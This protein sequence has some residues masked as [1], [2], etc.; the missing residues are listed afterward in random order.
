MPRDVHVILT[1]HWDR[2]WI[3]SYEE[4]RYRLVRLFDKALD[5]LEAEPELC[6][7]ADGQTVL[8]DDYL[9]VRPAN[10]ERL[11]ALTRAGRLVFGPWYVLGDQFLACDE[12]LVRN[13]AIG[14]AQAADYGGAMREGYVPDSF[15]SVAALP[16]I[17]N[18]FGITSANLGRGS[19]TGRQDRSQH[20]F[21]WQ[22]ADG[23]RVLALDIGYG[24]GL[25]LSYPDIWAN[26]AHTP[27]TPALALEAA[28]A[29]LAHQAPGFPTN[30]VYASA[31]VDHME[32]RPGMGAILA[33][34]N[35]AL[36]DTFFASTPAR[37]LDAARGEVE[38]Q[39]I[40]LE[41]VA[42]EMRGD[43]ISPMSLQGVLS[44][45]M[46]LKIGNRRAE[47]ALT[48]LLEPL[49]A[50]LYGRAYDHADVIRHA[51]KMVLQSQ[52]H[53]SICATNDDSTMQ[54]IHARVRSVNELAQLASE[55]LL[56]EA[57]PEV[58]AAPPALPELVLFGGWPGGG[59]LTA[60]TLVRLPQRLGAARYTVLN[61]NGNAV[62]ALSVLAERQ[63]DLETYY[64]ADR[65]LL[66][67]NVKENTAKA[68][69][70]TYT[71]ARLEVNLP[72]ASLGFHTLQLE[73]AHANPS[74][75]PADDTH[76]END[77]LALDV[78]QDGRLMLTHKPS[79]R[80]SEPFG[81]FE[82]MAE[83]GNAYDSL[84]VAGDQ[85]R[86]SFDEARVTSRLV[87]CDAVAQELL[88]TT[89]W[90]LPA[91]L[92]GW[93]WP[94]RRV[95]PPAEVAAQRSSELVTLEI[96]TLLRLAAGSERL[97]AVT[98]L[99]NNARLHRLRLG[100]YSASRE[101]VVAG[102]HFSAMTRPWGGPT[103]PMTDWLRLGDGFTFSGAGL[104]EYEARAPSSE[105]LVTLLR[106]CDCLGPAA[107]VN[108]EDL[109]SPLALGPH[110]LR[111]A[112]GFSDCAAAAARWAA[113]YLSPVLAHGSPAPMPALPQA[114]AQLEHPALVLSALKRSDDNRAWIVRFWNASDKALVTEVDLGLPA[115]RCQRVMLSEEPTGTRTPELLAPG[116][117]R[118]QVDAH[119][120]V[121]LRFSD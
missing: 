43:E 35:Q 71:L 99:D 118:L 90:Q 59:T 63:M 24:N 104:Y 10:R 61:N 107:G 60:D 70:A 31:G 30:A 74:Q 57:L 25:A 80:I 37:F 82:D 3:Q 91:D 102:G 95:W 87:R 2:E 100:M 9:A 45:D 41:T 42:G 77:L 84:R 48:R 73:D 51:W 76:L 40:Q 38:A 8:I 28:E 18:G 22:S 12:A 108:F 94:A 79:G 62:G 69:T 46:H 117:V 106:S 52:P 78:A 14:F 64:A 116:R 103:R 112:F 93:D 53:D 6:F 67:L 23:S 44:T 1:T 56:H 17:L 86:Y 114:L 13:L 27:A 33:H 55:R 113:S 120:I 5:I 29:I 34:L 21:W 58:S 7:V 26:I 88:V 36:P 19:Q 121:T 4:Y 89:R 101:D 15:G 119:E 110:E 75:F 98:R 49:N 65:T 96:E 81:W 66:R 97:E 111:Y 72:A 54:D 16:A 50:A 68:D 39:D 20:L 11:Q 83:A 32:L 92:V 109:R 105:V 47:L 115:E 85:P